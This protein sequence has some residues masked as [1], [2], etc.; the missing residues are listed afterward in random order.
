MSNKIKVLGILFIL[1]TLFSSIRSQGIDFDANFTVAGQ[2]TPGTIV[3][4]TPTS[5]AFSCSASS[6]DI[7][8]WRNN[9]VAAAPTHCA[10]MIADEGDLD[11]VLLPPTYYDAEQ[12]QLQLFLYTGDPFYAT[13]AQAAEHIYRDEYLVPNGYSASGY[14]G[15]STGLATDYL[16]NNDT[17]SKDAVDGLSH[18]EAYCAFTAYEEG[19][20]A[21]TDA[22]RNGLMREIAWCLVN[23]QQQERIG[24]TPQS[25]RQSY[26]EALL[27]LSDVDMDDDPQPFMMGLAVWALEREFDL[28]LSKGIPDPRLLPAIKKM[29]DFLWTNWYDQDTNCFLY[30]DGD[31]SYSQSCDTTNLINHAYAFLYKHGYGE[32]YRC[33]FRRSF[34]GAA[35]GGYFAGSKQFNQLNLFAFQALMDVNEIAPIGSPT[36]TPAPTPTATA[37]PTPTVTPTPGPTIAWNP[38]TYGTVLGDWDFADST[39]VLDAGDDSASDGEGV[40][41]VVDKAST[42]HNLVQAT[43]GN[44]YSCQTNEQ[45]A[46]QIIRTDGNDFFPMADMKAQLDGQAGITIAAVFKTPA[47]LVAYGRLVNVADSVGNRIT[48]Y[49]MS[50]ATGEIG[51][52][53]KGQ[54]DGDAGGMYTGENRLA[55]NT[56]YRLILSVNFSAN[57]AKLVIN[58]ATFVSS[59]NI[60]SSGNSTF[61]NA[62]G[63]SDMPGNR[64]S[65]TNLAYDYGQILFYQG[66]MDDTATAALDGALKSRWGL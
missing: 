17:D 19:A 44:Q 34:N 43:A 37:T 6:A 2:P 23:F 10:I 20:I 33:Q 16:L 28:Q 60:E 4:P 66:A 7:T 62:W 15:F 11:T 57:S 41:T 45:N 61:E 1:I 21:A 40:K 18:K 36:W 52:V 53:M 55:V 13:C 49:L 56:W 65:S 22:S 50:P 30:N 8:T 12:V 25:Y 64:Y 46:L 39:K 9:T 3:T 29:A 31:L 24:L 14:W 48:I 59:T 38:A 51:V 47:E 32:V 5:T 63:E 27:R 35:T 54:D 26:I 42:P 58:G